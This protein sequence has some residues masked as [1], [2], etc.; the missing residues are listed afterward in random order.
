MSSIGVNDL[1]FFD[2]YLYRV[3]L[4]MLRKDGPDASGLYNYY[5]NRVIHGQCALSPYDRMLFEYVLD[6]FDRVERRIVH[7]GI[8]LGTLTSALATAG[9]SVAGIEQ[10]GQRLRGAG[11]LHAA[12][13]QAWPD[14][15]ERYE[16]IAGQYPKVVEGTPW[17]TPTTLLIFTNCGAGW[18]DELTTQIIDS[19]TTVGDVILDARLFGITRDDEKDRQTLIER[20][21]SRGFKTR[22]IGHPPSHG[23]FHHFRHGSR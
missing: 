21:K 8:G 7:A 12:L 22:A 20:I 15:G 6:S 13:A 14:A 11:Q 2:G 18:S 17:L 3:M 10:D 4:D 19:F 9:Y 16:L 5:E 1:P 23:Y